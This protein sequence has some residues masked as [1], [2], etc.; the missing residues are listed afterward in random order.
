MK[1]NCTIFLML[2]YWF[3]FPMAL[4]AQDSLNNT[5]G[6]RSKKE[7]RLQN[8]QARMYKRLER[9]LSDSLDYKTAYFN[10]MLLEDLDFRNFE[11]LGWWQFQYNS[12]LEKIEDSQPAT[13]LDSLRISYAKKTV[14]SMMGVVRDVYEAEAIRP[15][16][17]RDYPALVFLLMLR[18]IV[19]PKDYVAY[20]SII[21]YSSKMEDYG[22]ALFYLEAALKNGYTDLETLNAL[23]ETGLLRIMP[24]FQAVLEV[25]LKKGRYGIREEE[26]ESSDVE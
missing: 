19:N 24:E 10:Y 20:L 1:H 4:Q 21:S 26:T 15:P 3:L 2:C 12:L 11:N 7:V 6:E 17:I 14:V 18:T 13:P 16:E 22:T 23:P 5:G 8:K 9:K 25:Y